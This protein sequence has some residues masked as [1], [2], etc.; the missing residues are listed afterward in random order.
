MKEIVICTVD[1][2]T[3][4]DNYGDAEISRLL[5]GS[6]TEWSQVTDDEYNNLIAYQASSYTRQFIIVRK[7]PE[8]SQSEPTVSEYLAIADRY[9][10]DKEKQRIEQIKN[11]KKR[12]ETELIK[13]KEKDLKDLEKL[14]QKVAELEKVNKQ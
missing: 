6:I 1:T 7:I 3:A 2:M 14:K 10:K 12:K 13:R 4:Y 8:E 11:D 5:R 9:V